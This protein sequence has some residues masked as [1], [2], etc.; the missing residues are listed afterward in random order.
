MQRGKKF[1]QLILA[2]E[3]PAK[4][5]S[6]IDICFNENVNFAFIFITK[7]KAII[8]FVQNKTNVKKSS[9]QL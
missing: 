6:E 5:I 3:K 2:I 7:Q 9:E 8:Q 1:K 4:K